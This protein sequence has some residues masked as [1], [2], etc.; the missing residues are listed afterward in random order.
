TAARASKAGWWAMAALVL[1]ACGGGG[2]GGGG[3]QG[4]AA[5]A[6]PP[7]TGGMAVLAVTSDFQAFNPVVNT[8]ATTDDVIR[9]MLFTPLI[10][11][12]ARL[13]P[14]PWL[15]QR[16]E[17]SDTA[18]VFH[19]RNDVKWHDGRPVTAEDVKFTF[20]LAK[21]TTTAS[22][23]GSAYLALVKSATVID[24]H[25]IRFSFTAPHAQALDDFWWAPI[26]KHLL[27]STPG[28]QLSQAA[29]NRQPVGS[30]P[31]KFT[32]WKPNETLTLEANTAF[33]AG[34]GGRPK[35]DRVVFRI[36]PEP[37][38]MVTELVNGTTDVIGWTLQPDQAAQVQAQPGL[39]LKHYPSREFTYLAWNGTRAPFNDPAVRRA[40]GMA[41]DRASIIKG[42]MRGFAVPASGMIPDWSPMSSRTP[43]PPFDVNGARQALAQ[44]GWVDSDRDGIVE[45]NGKPLRFVLMVNTANRTHQ[46]MAQVLQQEL[47]A[48]GADIEVRTQEFQT[49]LRQFKSRDYDAVIA[50]WSLDT[51]KVDPTPLFSCE[52]ARV[53]NSA[54]RTG[55]CNPQADALM[56]QGLRGTEPAQVKQTW[57]Q[58]S[59]IL[60][61]DQPVTFLFWSEDMA[62]VGPRLQGVEM[63][64]RSK[65]ANVK[66]WWI[67]ADR[68]R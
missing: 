44:A 2:G 12:D 17:L 29:Y 39:T 63:D 32:A 68:R 9:F 31:F 5:A 16:W 24:P 36:I 51:F 52:Q 54:N 1:A 47:K 33:P 38:T 66:D 26:P 50:N 22:L 43:P 18:V 59:Q 62:G 7:Q 42:L 28:A 67:P 10:Q 6:G 23:I 64:A 19:L 37:T 40:M 60:Q 8:H 27:E 34:L 65:L 53:P 41:I 48:V 45:K 4:A 21:D 58:Y 61:Q 35:L 13:N 11:Y 56:A 49:M 46:D 30:G 14:V 15:A 25:T 55:Y 20:D 57:A 3:G